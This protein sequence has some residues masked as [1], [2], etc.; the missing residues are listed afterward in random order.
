MPI[1]VDPSETTEP[2][3]SADGVLTATPWASW[4]SVGVDVDWSAVSLSPWRTTVHR[5][6]GAVTD[7]VRSG[8]LAHTPGGQGYVYDHEAPLAKVVT[9]QATGYDSHGTL[10]GTSDSVSVYLGIE[11]GVAWLKSVHN[12]SLS[13]EVIVTASIGEDYGVET[14]VF[15]VPN[16][17]GVAHRVVWSAGRNLPTG[18]L[19]VMVDSLAEYAAVRELLSA[20]ALLLQSTDDLALLPEDTYVEATSISVGRIEGHAGWEYR[21]L[22]APF[23]AIQRPATIGSRL[24]V[25]DWSYDHLTSTFASNTAADAAFASYVRRAAGS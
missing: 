18:T 1:I 2:V 19:T 8:D 13:R 4:A 23:Q 12:P 15:A 11:Q 17:G 24:R 5:T 9:Y 22:V 16:P 25:P 21:S 10:L 14:E 7:V 3:A 20:G 6:I